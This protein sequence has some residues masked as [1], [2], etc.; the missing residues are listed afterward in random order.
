MMNRGESKQA[1]WWE[2]QI[3]G[4]NE[5]S[6]EVSQAIK[7]VNQFLVTTKM[8]M[9]NDVSGLNDR[10]NQIRQIAR[11]RETGRRAGITIGRKKN[12]ATSNCVLL[13]LPVK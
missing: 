4:C 9:D 13:L 11:G 2:A 12:K 7:T 6:E 8:I 5:W 1:S 3:K 10:E